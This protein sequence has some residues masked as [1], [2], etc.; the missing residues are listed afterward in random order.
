MADTLIG[1]TLF[2]WCNF[3]FQKCWCA[4]WMHWTVLLR[5]SW[6]SR[7]ASQVINPSW[8]GSLVRRSII[9]QTSTQR[10][11]YFQWVHVQHI[12][13]GFSP[14]QCSDIVEM[15]TSIISDIPLTLC[16][17][18]CSTNFFRCCLSVANRRSLPFSSSKFVFGLRKFRKKNRTLRSQ[19][20]PSPN[21]VGSSLRIIMTKH[22]LMQIKRNAFSFSC[23]GC[24]ICN[25][26]C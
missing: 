5:L 24:G 26:L 18:Y 8:N 19:V 14:C 20:D 6:R 10:I 3:S 2:W 9:G 12:Y 13:R 4:S 11:L 7:F 17:A 1:T 23:S 21:K 15:M 16:G 22:D 25:I